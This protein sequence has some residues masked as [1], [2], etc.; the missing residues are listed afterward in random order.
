MAGIDS[1]TQ[2]KIAPRLEQAQNIW[3][4]TVRAD[5]RPH[6][7]PI[8]FVWWDGKVWIST[9]ETSQKIANIERNPRVSVALEDGANPVVIEGTAEV[10]RD[11]ETRDALAP[12]FLKKY[13]WD[14]RADNEYGTLIGV[15]P[16][17][18][19]LGG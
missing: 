3:L 17:R 5:G 11:A 18:L 4:A 8:W 9:G 15:T 6:L 2:E 7:V 12:H 16:V 13:E 19:L 10:Y 14:F 1:G